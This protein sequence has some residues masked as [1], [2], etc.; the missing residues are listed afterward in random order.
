MNHDTFDIEDL[1][2][3]IR[4]RAE[5]FVEPA[6][7]APAPEDTSIPVR[8]DAEAPGD[9]EDHSL[10]L[11]DTLT[12]APHRV[13]RGAKG[14]FI[15]YR[16]GVLGIGSSVEDVYHQLKQQMEHANDL[17]LDQLDLWSRYEVGLFGGQP[18]RDVSKHDAELLADQLARFRPNYLVLVNAGQVKNSF[19]DRSPQ[20]LALLTRAINQGALR[21]GQRPYTLVFVMNQ[22]IPE[23]IFP[24]YM[25][26]CQTL[27]THPAMMQFL[28]S[29][30]SRLIDYARF[31]LRS[32]TRNHLEIS[33]RV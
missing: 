20:H 6:A 18:R 26:A 27:N 33:E 16:I 11:I 5:E 17:L 2:Q 4:L 31:E 23:K 28:P 12:R 14:R 19:S 25:R 9:P 21:G 29:E 13:F 3:V 8:V 7:R 30:L 10:R 15:R 1:S 24:I 32:Y 22:L